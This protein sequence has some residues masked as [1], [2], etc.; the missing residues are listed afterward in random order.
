LIDRDGGEAI[1]ITY[2]DTE[3]DLRSSAAEPNNLRKA[4]AETGRLWIQAVDKYE[5][6][7]DS[8]R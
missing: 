3:D 6:A 2:W 4:A 5:V 7:L 1:T 8:R